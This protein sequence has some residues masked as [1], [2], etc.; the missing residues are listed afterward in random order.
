MWAADFEVKEQHINQF[1]SYPWD[2]EGR[3]RNLVGLQVHFFDFEEAKCKCHDGIETKQCMHK[4]LIAV[5]LQYTIYQGSGQLMGLQEEGGARPA[6][7]HQQHSMGRQEAVQAVF[8][9]T[10]HTTGLLP[11]RILRVDLLSVGS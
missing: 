1:G 10:V 3:G 8:T 5:V 2:S 6:K 7:N 4:G 9:N 11:F